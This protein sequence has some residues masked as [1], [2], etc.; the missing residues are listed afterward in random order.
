MEDL[1][2]AAELWQDAPSA[3]ERKKLYAQYGVCWSAFWDLSYFNPTRCLVIE[4]MHNFFEGLVPYHC[5]I[6]LG[7][8]HPEE[9]HCH[10]GKPANPPQLTVAH[11]LLAKYPAPSWLSFKKMTVVVLK[12]LCTERGLASPVVNRGKQLSKSQIVDVIYGSLV[13]TCRLSL[14][15]TLD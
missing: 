11:N 2:Q 4:G 13:S 7:I 1:R 10:Q 8:D 9:C 6:V 14:M 5:R 12:V 15:N 3:S